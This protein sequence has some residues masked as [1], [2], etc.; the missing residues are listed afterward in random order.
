M[1]LEKLFLYLQ[2]FFPFPYFRFF[3]LPD[4]VRRPPQPPPQVPPGARVARP[5]RRRR[6]L[7]PQLP[8]LRRR[9][10]GQGDVGGAPLGEEEEARLPRTERGRGGLLGGRGP[11]SD[12][13]RALLASMMWNEFKR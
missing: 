7:E 13:L 8:R 6:G 11:N 4:R 3:P 2:H 10:A 12:S 1:S 9:A 5:L